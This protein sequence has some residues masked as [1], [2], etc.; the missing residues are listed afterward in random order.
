[1]N[2]SLH[3]TLIYDIFS[4]ELLLKAKDNIF[5]GNKF[6]NSKKLCAHI[7]P[8]SPQTAR[9]PFVIGFIQ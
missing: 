9:L 8:H 6:R 7:L 3:Y 5:G 1:M 4:P 2:I